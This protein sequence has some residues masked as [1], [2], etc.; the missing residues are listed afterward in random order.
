[1]VR[2][3]G[4]P[5]SDVVVLLDDDDQTTLPV[6]AVIHVDWQGSDA[7]ITQARIV[8]FSIGNAQQV[9]AVAQ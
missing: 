8:A 3:S 4:S 1:M 6:V 2:P 9:L 5:N 7:R